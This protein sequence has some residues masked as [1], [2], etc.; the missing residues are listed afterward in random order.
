MMV[1]VIECVKKIDERV[2]TLEKMS[3]APYKT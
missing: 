3:R 2:S 1:L